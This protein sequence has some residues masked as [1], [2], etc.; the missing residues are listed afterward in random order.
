MWVMAVPMLM[1]TNLTTICFN[2]TFFH[3][4]MRYSFTKC[5]SSDEWPSSWSFEKNMPRKIIDLSF[6]TNAF[7]NYLTIRW[8]VP[9][10]SYF[11]V[12]EMYPHCRHRKDP[13]DLECL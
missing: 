3:N 9:M 6:N 7:I 5:Q 2:D 10:N 13:T 11:K 1:L 8:M 12:Q 4:S